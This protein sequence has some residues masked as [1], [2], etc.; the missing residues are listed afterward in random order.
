MQIYYWLFAI[1]LIIVIIIVVYFI[2]NAKY[3]NKPFL[4]DIINNGKASILTTPNQQ[5]FNPSTFIWKN[6]IY[7]AYR[8]SP[9]TFCKHIFHTGQIVKNSVRTR[10]YIVIQKPDKSLVKVQYIKSSNYK[11]CAEQY[12]DPRPILYAGKLILVVNDPQQHKCKNKMALMILSLKTLEQNISSIAPEIVVP[13][14]YPSNR[15]EKNWMPFVFKDELFFIYQINPHVILK[16]D[17]HTG[18]CIKIAETVNNCIPSGLRGGTPPKQLNKD[19]YITFGHV[20]KKIFGIKQI[21]TTVAYLYE[22]RPPFSIVKVSKEFFIDNDFE[23]N[24]FKNIIQFASGLDIHDEKLYLTF[25]HNDCVSKM[26]IISV[27]NVLQL[28]EQN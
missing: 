9:Y 18:Q 2:Q 26:L 13:L 22:A 24:K 16:C 25:G 6:K 15:I 10:N 21:Y 27:N 14:V 1:L 12:E 17:I 5:M 3:C 23:K 20:K 4:S 7:I 8:H 19:Y 11:K 28:F